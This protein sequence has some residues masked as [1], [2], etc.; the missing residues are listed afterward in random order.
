MSSTVSLYRKYRSKSFDQVIGQDHIVSTLM[1][2]IKSGNISHAYLFTGPRGTG[3]TSVARILAYAINDLEYSLSQDHIDIIEIDAASNRRIDEIRE[4]R[5]KAHIAPVSARYKVYI[6][7]EVHMLT[8]EAFNALL[9]TLEEPPS[10]VVFMLATTEVHKVPATI[11]SRTQRHSFRP[12]T[13]QDA[14]KHLKTVAIAEKIPIDDAALELIAEHADGS[15]R[16]ALSLLGQVSSLSNSATITQ[17]DIKNMLGLSSNQELEEIINTIATNSPKNIIQALSTSIASGKQPEIMAS[18]LI[19][20]LRNRE[21]YNNWINLIEDLVSI[22]ASPKP[23]ISLELALIRQIP[24]IPHEIIVNN[25]SGDDVEQNSTK[26]KS[27]HQSISASG[28]K[29]KA[30]KEITSHNQESIQA[31]TDA[32][33]VKSKEVKNQP[34]A[35]TNEDSYHPSLDQEA[36]NKVINLIKAENNAIASIVRSSKPNLSDDQLRLGVKFNFHKKKLEDKP[37]LNLIQTSVHAV[38]GK[39]PQISINIDQS[40][41]ADTLQDQENETDDIASK[42]IDTFGGGER[43][44]I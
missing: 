18:Q 34:K 25:K 9:K 39:S 12:S 32:D 3:K 7:D 43:I 23:S 21:D 14:F 41:V 6:I 4:L 27:N 38:T 5:E 37:I 15:Y 42:V 16:D 1:N 17:A 30:L 20:Y 11:V 22:G 13:K 26:P 29:P 8:K 28:Q 44:D 31:D 40:L 10:H 35:S 24:N 33:R 2:S 36:W 19:D